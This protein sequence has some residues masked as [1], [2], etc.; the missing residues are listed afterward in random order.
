MNES[1]IYAENILKYYG[2]N[3]K[4]VEGRNHY[5]GYPDYKCDRGHVE[6]KKIQATFQIQITENQ[7]KK[8]DELVKNNEKVYLMVI[9]KNID[10]Y[11]LFEIKE[12][13]IK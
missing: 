6:V 4:K 12:G 3:P 11:F 13:K 10:K 1:E 5:V 9:N 8:W 2:W 7:I